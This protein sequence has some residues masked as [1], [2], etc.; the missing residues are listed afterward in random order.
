[1]LVTSWSPTHSPGVIAAV[2][3]GVRV[4]SMPGVRSDMLA[5]GGLTADYQA[6][7]KLTER[8][9]EY[10]ARG[11]TVRLTTAAGTDLVSDLGGWAR[12]PFLDDGSL[13]KGT[14]GVGNMPAGEVAV[15]PMEQATRGRVV[16]DLTI[17]TTPAPLGEPV[18]IDVEGGRVVAISGGGEARTFEAALDAHGDSSRVVAEIALGTNPTALH[19]GVVI[20]DEKRLG[21]A[22]IG[23]GHA[24]G[25][26]GLNKSS[27]HAD[28]IFGGVTMSIDGVELVR[29][30]EVVTQALRREGLE[31]FAGAGGRYCQ[32][33]ADV[34]VV[35][36]L[37]YAAWTDV[38]GRQRWAQVGDA[39]A[40]RVAAQVLGSGLLEAEPASPQARALELMSRYRVVV[41][42]G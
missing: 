17:S 22:H 15:A 34:R 39:D 37:L 6:V 19:I 18:V 4:L 42:A 36:E 11:A 31:A 30:G 35:E 3:A 13:P 8:W 21:T 24:V 5:Q 40:A 12:P 29:D 14:G 16:A 26:G 38:P 10:F 9:G 2:R 33:P 32:G 25:L 27:I 20:E 41:A 28:A 1:M 7:K 23:F